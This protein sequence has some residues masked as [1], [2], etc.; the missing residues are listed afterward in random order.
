MQELSEQLQEL[1]D[2]GFIRPGHSSWGAPVLFVEKKDGS[3]WMSINYRE[4]NKLTIKNHYPLL[5]I[6]DLPDD[7]V[8]YCDASNQ[9]FGCV[10]IQ[11]DKVTAY[12]SQQLKIHKKSYTTH[13]LELGA[14]VFALKNWRH[15]LYETK[16]V[17]YT[18]HNS[19]QHIF[20]QNELNMCLRR[21]I[22]LFSDYDCKIRYNLVKANVV[23]NAL[24]R[25]ERVKPRRV[26]A[27]LKIIQSSVN[28]KILEVQMEAS[29]VDNMSTL[30]LRGLDQQMVRKEDGGLYFMD[31]IWVPLVGS[32]RTLIMDETYTSRE[33]RLI[34]LEMLQETTDKVVQIKERLKVA[35]DR[36]K[37]YA[38]IGGKLAPKY[39]RP[40]EIIKRIGS[41]ACQIRL[42]HELSSV[43]DTFHV[44]NLKK[45][46]ADAN[47]HVPLE[48]I[49][50]DKTLRFVKEH[51]KIMDREVKRL[52]R[53]RIPIVKVR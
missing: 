48:E 23:A 31:Q 3:F 13:D 14:V 49:N 11:R 26:R 51:V 15:Y 35:R 37:S 34:G 36:Q 27:M 24:S 2:K 46:L 4:L 42:P 12:A 44:S 5:R 16:S 19:L 29:K 45:C 20:D 7:F 22:K 30:M 10:L 1:Q 38:I 9:G 52:K 41:V 28:D 6:D 25:K 32:V 8:V 43:H 40:F 50:V 53:S 17:I 47:L 18:D 21:W 33:S 39:V